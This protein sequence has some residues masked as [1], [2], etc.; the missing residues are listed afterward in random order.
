[1]AIKKIKNSEDLNQSCYSFHGAA[2]DISVVKKR[3][4]IKNNERIEWNGAP[5]AVERAPK[6]WLLMESQLLG[7]IGKI[8]TNDRVRRCHERLMTSWRLKA[9]RS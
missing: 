8:K 5:V 1:M 2:G 3:F 7:F 4:L 6:V 9:L